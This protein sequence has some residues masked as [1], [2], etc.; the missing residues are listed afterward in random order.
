MAAVIVAFLNFP[1]VVRVENICYVFRVNES[2]L[3]FHLLQ[4]SVDCALEK[5]TPSVPTGC[6]VPLNGIDYKLRADQLLSTVSLTKQYTEL[7]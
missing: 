2:R 5:T 7:H 4:H 3:D 6:S 1:G